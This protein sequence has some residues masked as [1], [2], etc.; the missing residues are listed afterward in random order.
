MRPALQKTPLAR[1]QRGE[2]QPT[3]HKAILPP[4]KRKGDPEV[5]TENIAA[6]DS[7]VCEER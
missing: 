4:N 6:A 5:T 7:D 3:T 2:R 1:R